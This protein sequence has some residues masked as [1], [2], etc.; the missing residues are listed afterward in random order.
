MAV[1]T[2]EEREISK[3]VESVLRPRLRRER[4]IDLRKKG[5]TNEQ[6]ALQYDIKSKSISTKISHWNL[7]GWN[8]GMDIPENT[9]YTDNKNKPKPVIPIQPENHIPEVSNM[10]EHP[11]H[12]TSGNVE[13]IDAIEAAVEGLP[14]NEAVL[15]ANIIKYTWR[16]YRKNGLEDLHKARWYLDRLIQRVTERLN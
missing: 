13:C 3:H 14:P 2:D 6:I 10:V 4:Y 7:T 8:P 9:A 5:H 11:P 12:Y 15:V 1:M 16:Y